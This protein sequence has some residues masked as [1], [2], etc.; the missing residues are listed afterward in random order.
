MSSKYALEC[1]QFQANRTVSSGGIEMKSK[2]VP[3]IS[4]ERDIW[5]LPTSELGSLKIIGIGEISHN[6]GGLHAAAGKAI[7]ELIKKAEV[8]TLLFEVPSGAVISI[9]QKIQNGEK[10][11]ER[12]L[13]GLY[14]VWRSHQVLDFFNSLAKFNRET[15][16]KVSVFGVD[17]RQP[18]YEASKVREFL[19]NGNSR[20]EFKLLE[21]LPGEGDMVSF[22]EFEQELIIGKRTLSESSVNEG[23]TLLSKVK[24]LIANADLAPEVRFETEVAVQSLMSWFRMYG[25]AS[26]DQ[27]MGYIMRD[28]GMA[29]KTV[30]LLEARGGPIVVWTH[31]AHLLY[32][33][34]KAS[35]SNSYVKYGKVLGTLLK[36]KYKEGFSTLA[37]GA[38]TLS[39]GG[40]GEEVTTFKTTADSL[41][42]MVVGENPFGGWIRMS[43]TK[44]KSVEIARTKDLDDPK[45]VSFA[46]YRLRGD[47]QFSYFLVVREALEKK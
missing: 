46:H 15:N 40:R 32:N 8:N 28:Q 41:E 2:C 16:R 12:D 27:R 22:R 38:Q 39:I 23:V 4:A 37:V 5:N 42:S 21:L 13:E 43:D 44:G 18:Y 25:E 26:K 7:L 17:V 29:D 36:E 47:E 35:S 6:S 1:D 14:S 19:S 3:S 9:N 33:S 45:K 30:A 34:P 11:V 20:L 10:L 24:N 31:L